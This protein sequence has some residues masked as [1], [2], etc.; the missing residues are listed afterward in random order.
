MQVGVRFGLKKFGLTKASAWKNSKKL[1]DGGDFLGDV[2]DLLGEGG[3]LL[4]NGGD[5]FGNGG[6][7]LGDGG[8][9]N[10]ISTLCES[11]KSV[12]GAARLSAD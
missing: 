5:L 2:G 4:G 11:S 12:T 7:L 10:V 9:H 1:S 8:H 6:D 3:D